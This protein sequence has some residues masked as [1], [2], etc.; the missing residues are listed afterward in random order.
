MAKDRRI[1]GIKSELRRWTKQH[2]PFVSIKEEIRKRLFAG[3]KKSG[4]ERAK[5]Y[6]LHLDI[7][8]F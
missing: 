2:S 8:H 7:F 5:S 6:Y 4:N 1:L 3:S